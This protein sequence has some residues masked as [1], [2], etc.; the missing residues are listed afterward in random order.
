MLI[1]NLPVLAATSLGPGRNKLFARGI[2]DGS[3]NG[4]SQANL[5][6]YLGE[7]RLSYAGPDPDINLFDVRRVEVLT[8]PYGTLYGT[9]ALGGVMR[10]EANAPDAERAGGRFAAHLSDVR[11]GATG[12]EIA[13]M[14][15]LPLS[16]G[17]LAVRLVGYRKVDAGYIDDVARGLS[18]IN[19]VTTTGGRVVLRATGD[20]DVEAELGFVY[21]QIEA[22]DSQ[23]SND[24][25]DALVTRNSVAQPYSSEFLMPSVTLRKSWGNLHLVSATGW[26]RQAGTELSNNFRIFTVLEQRRASFLSHETR[27]SG[28]SDRFGF[29]AG[30]SLARNLVRETR[31]NRILDFEIED[32]DLRSRTN[33][34]ALFGEIR[35]SLSRTISATVGG[36][37]NYIGEARRTH[38]D[39]LGPDATAR[40]D[41]FSSLPSAA[42]SWSPRQPILLFLAYRSGSRGSNLLPVPDFAAPQIL[43]SD[44]DRLSSFE[45]G[46]RYSAPKLSLASTIS[47]TCWKDV[48]SD[49][50]TSVGNFHTNN[51]GNARIW[52]LEANGTWAPLPGLALSAALF[53][54]NAPVFRLSPAARLQIPDHF[55]AARFRIP[56][57]ASASARFGLAYETS[58]FKG[59]ELRLAAAMRYYGNSEAEFESRQP[60][61][62]EIGTEARLTWN[63]WVMTLGITNLTDVRGNRFAIGNRF[64]RTLDEPQSTPLQP[65]TLRLGF[66]VDF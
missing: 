24:E 32:F 9:G 13:G 5:S 19:R 64:T 51:L 8:G 34:L 49:L 40:F 23:Y 3:F 56:N 62:L 17:R 36:R 2:A 52:G 1:D 66:E 27:L 41:S 29:V 54:N 59:A 18:N 30:I 15:N 43:I 42:L 22:R 10:I 7:L 53:L 48:Q 55:L 65:R 26:S 31:K 45:A 63:R 47:Y 12:N 21:Q 50:I 39:L 60:E 28:G 44:P 35:A 25:H 38:F 61:Y 11:H 20:G 4:Q 37:L 14:A 6:L 33:D 57:I 58:L 46:W 16:S